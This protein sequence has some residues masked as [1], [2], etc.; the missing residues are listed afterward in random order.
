MDARPTISEFILDLGG[1][2]ALNVFETTEEISGSHA[3]RA[4]AESS[5]TSASG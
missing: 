4:T 5:T 3:S 1:V 2:A